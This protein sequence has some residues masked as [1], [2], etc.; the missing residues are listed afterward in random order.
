[1][2][3]GGLSMGVMQ[4]LHAETDGAHSKYI[5]WKN[6]ALAIILLSVDPSL[7]YLLGD[8]TDPT[9]VWEKLSTQFQKKTWQTN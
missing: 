3:C 8:P 6:H 4:H 1:M 2:G 9:A 5:S 7:L